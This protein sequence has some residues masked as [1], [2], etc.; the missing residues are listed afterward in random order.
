M[1]D[2]ITFLPI[3]SRYSSN[4]H[5]LAMH[6]QGKDTNTPPACKQWSKQYRFANLSEKT[7]WRRKCTECISWGSVIHYVFQWGK[8]CTCKAFWLWFNF[9]YVET[10]NSET[11]VCNLSSAIWFLHSNTSTKA[12]L[13]QRL[14]N[15]NATDPWFTHTEQRNVIITLRRCVTSDSKL[16]L[17]NQKAA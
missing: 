2:I 13:T 16:V 9:G 4:W 1:G 6:Q 14:H 10:F 17:R 5:V 15:I 8:T 11:T 7:K 3:V 12:L